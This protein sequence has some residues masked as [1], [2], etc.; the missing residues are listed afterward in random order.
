MKTYL[1]L[2]GKLGNQPCTNIFLS[3]KYFLPRKIPIPKMAE[4]KRVKAP[5][6]RRFNVR[7]IAQPMP[8]NPTLPYN[9]TLPAEPT[10]T[11]VT[12]MVT[13]QT[14]V[15]ISAATTAT[16]TS[17]TV[18]NLV[19]GKFK[20]IPCPTRKFQEG[21]GPSSPSCNKPQEEQQP[22][23]AVTARAPQKRE[24]TPWPNTMPASTNLF[25][26]R[27]SWPIPPTEAP[28]VIKN[29]KAEEKIPPRIAAIPK[30][31]VLNKP[32]SNK[33]AEEEC[34]W[35]LHCPICAKSTPN[36]KAKSTEDWNGERQ[37]NQQRN[38]YP[39]SP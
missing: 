22:E 37:D 19:Q 26:V 25:D 30:I 10:P 39:R 15:A 38:Y 5:V 2:E 29:E 33:L 36:T 34:R 7:V 23:A 28:T 21:E 12:S 4:K 31:L 8:A 13:T 17:V 14:P 20:G 35:G 11:V 3:N 1:E 9:P 16:S 18:Y 27:P 24:D 32:Q 6:R